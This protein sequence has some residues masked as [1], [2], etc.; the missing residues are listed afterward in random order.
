MSRK[1][2][3]TGNAQLILYAAHWM[4]PCIIDISWGWAE[5]GQMAPLPI[6]FFYLRIVV[7]ATELKKCK[8]NNLGRQSGKGVYVF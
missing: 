8:F 5:R 6:I 1:Q 2:R 7:L 4:V 3:V